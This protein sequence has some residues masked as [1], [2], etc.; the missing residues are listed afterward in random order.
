LQPKFGELLNHVR[1]SLALAFTSGVPTLQAIISYHFDMFP[2][3]F[4][5]KVSP[6]RLLRMK[7]KR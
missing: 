1:F 7:D 4:S 3:R 2:P 5:V 6:L